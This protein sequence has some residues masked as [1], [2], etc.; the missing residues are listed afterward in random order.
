MPFLVFKRVEKARGRQISF[1]VGKFRWRAIAA[2]TPPHGFAVALIKFLPLAAMIC[3]KNGRSAID[4]NLLGG[5]AAG[6]TV[7]TL[8]KGGMNP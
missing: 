8:K 6:M 2:P 7:R 1:L 4:P 3:G 5:F